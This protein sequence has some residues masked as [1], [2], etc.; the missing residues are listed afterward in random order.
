MWADFD[1]LSI[2]YHC[3]DNTGPD[4]FLHWISLDILKS[5]INAIKI[6]VT[7]SHVLKFE[8][9]DLLSLRLCF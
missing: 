7:L 1:Q 2:I 9:F 8:Y 4:G 3:G 6:Q 5:S